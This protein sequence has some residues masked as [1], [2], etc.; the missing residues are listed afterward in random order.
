MQIDDMY[1]MDGYG[2]FVIQD[3]YMTYDGRK[4]SCQWVRRDDGNFFL[5]NTFGDFIVSCR[6]L[7]D[8]EKFAILME[9]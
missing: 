6:K 7:D 9:T 4:F 5:F 2:I 3:E 1:E 8:E